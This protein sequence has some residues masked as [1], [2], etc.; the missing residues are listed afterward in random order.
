[1]RRCAP[2]DSCHLCGRVSLVPWA[3]RIVL[4][5]SNASE[6]PEMTHLLHGF[7]PCASLNCHPHQDWSNLAASIAST[8]ARQ[9]NLTANPRP[10][11]RTG[12]VLQKPTYERLEGSDLRELSVTRAL[13]VGSG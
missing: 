3:V 4:C 13:R 2:Q 7:R 12:P 9:T 11:R 8:A 10:A 6:H 1:M 5:V